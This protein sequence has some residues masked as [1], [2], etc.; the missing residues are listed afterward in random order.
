MSLDVSKLQNVKHRPDGSFTARCPACAGTGGDAKGTH[1]IVFKDGKFA[2]DAN[3]GSHEHRSEI[4][5]LVSSDV[6]YC[7]APPKP[8]EIRRPK[9]EPSQTLM[10]LGRHGRHNSTPTEKSESS[11]TPP[12]DNPDD[13]N[14]PGL[15]L[16]RPQR[17][18][19]EYADLLQRDDDPPIR[20][21]MPP[22]IGITN[23][24]P[25]QLEDFLNS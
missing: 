15:E 2:C 25:E 4:F 8:I 5:R 19:D 21:F 18:D 1:L 6:K 17:P 22:C 23:P 16:C 11:Q 20:D 9:I 7:P 12:K 24:T 3:Q 10:I 13:K 14:S